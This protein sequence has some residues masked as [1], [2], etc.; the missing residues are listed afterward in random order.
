MKFKQIPFQS[1]RIKIDLYNYLVEVVITSDLEKAKEFVSKRLNDP[2]IQVEDFHAAGKVF[3]KKRYAPIMWLPFT[4]VD[5]V[6]LS[7]VS[8]E[9]FHLVHYLMSHV[10]MDLDDSSEEAYAYVMG[11]ITKQFWKNVK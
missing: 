10:G 3:K 7:V 2:Y 1:F 11:Y 4:P 6:S 5:N 8:H 9:I